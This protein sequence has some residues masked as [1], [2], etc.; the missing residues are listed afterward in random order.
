VV[1]I[2]EIIEH[3]YV[4]MQWQILVLYKNGE[5]SPKLHWKVEV[6]HCS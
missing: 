1:I 2:D 6:L 4:D 3:I 5:L